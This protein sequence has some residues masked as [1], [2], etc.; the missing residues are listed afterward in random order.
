MFIRTSTQRRADGSTLTH[1]Q[2]AESCWDPARKRS[3][4]RV[5]WNCGRA[6]DEATTERLRAL[7]RCIQRRLSP[8][9][10]VVDRPG[11]RLVDAWP[12]GDVWVLDALWKR[13]GIAGALQAALGDRRFSF[14]VERAV[15]A[16]VANRACAPASKLY[17]HEQW[18]RADVRVPG[19]E[20]LALHH[21]YR[22]MDVL[23]E[24]HGRVEEAVFN[25]VANLFNL[26]VELVFYDTTSVHFESEEEPGDDEDPDGGLRQRGYS[27]N[28]R[29]DATQ[30]VVG[31]AVTRDGFPV[32][33]WVF[34]GNTVDVTTVKRV[35][36][37]L[38]GW[39]LSRCV[40]VGDAGMVSE[41]NL[42]TLARAGGRYIVCVPM[43]RGGEVVEDVLS[44]AGRYK[45]VAD[46]LRVKE[47]VVGEGERRRRYAACH[48]PLEAARQAAHR[49][50][51]L[52]EL[53]AELASMHHAGHDGHSKHACGLRASRRYGRY[54][55]QDRRG[56]LAIDRAAVAAAAR[57]DGRFVVTTNDDSLS[58]E[59]M[60]LGYKQLQR[61]EEAWRRMKS[62]LGLRPVF[63]WTEAR[64]RAHV[65]ITVLALMLERA[66]EAAC[67]DTWR[68]IRD[69]LRQVK[70]AELAGPEGRVRQATEPGPAASKRLSAMKIDAPPLVWDLA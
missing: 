2:V 40:F 67:G 51:L 55:R 29:S 59:D 68:N 38:R 27:K 9:E 39:K 52:R 25:H 34:P 66:A 53:E 6:D 58:A 3:T 65:A 36:E 20:G 48:N 18:L 21:L 62:G 54:L 69:D 22:A 11:W 16:M 45:V 35:R 13:L 24:V 8:E 57:H 47:V 30:V 7:A 31:M 41:E 46:N 63:H 32:R 44:R 37:D 1:L 5:L 15:F 4:T 19:T 28:G 12:L 23:H 50:Q 61:A 43:H 26:D 14:P 49:E 10:M 56:N 33:H 60:A 64:I 70:L 17:A 42:A